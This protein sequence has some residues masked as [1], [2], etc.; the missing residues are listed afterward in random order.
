MKSSEKQGCKA[1]ESFSKEAFIDGEIQ[2]EMCLQKK[3]SPVVHVGAA[4]KE[5]MPSPL[6]PT[7]S[8]MGVAS[9]W[10]PV[11]EGLPMSPQ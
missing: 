7:P 11:I 2:G 9:N 6:G 5:N 4:P 1:R 8:L 3:A 10:V